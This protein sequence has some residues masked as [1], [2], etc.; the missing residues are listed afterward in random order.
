[1]TTSFSLSLHPQ[2]HED[3]PPSIRLNCLGFLLAYYS[4][5][6]WLPLFAD[7]L[8]KHRISVAPMPC[9]FRS[10]TLSSRLEH[11]R[12][13]LIPFELPPVLSR[14]TPLHNASYPHSSSPIPVQGPAPHP[15]FQRSFP[16]RQFPYEIGPAP[17]VFSFSFF[18]FLSV[19]PLNLDAL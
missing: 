2:L 4:L 14:I 9:L 12:Y 17:T 6:S 3:C 18:S 1:L 13:L 16:R 19:L 11:L 7:S 10:F 8:P 5:I 15:N